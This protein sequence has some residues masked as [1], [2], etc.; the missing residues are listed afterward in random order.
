ML[1]PGFIAAL[2][3]FHMAQEARRVARVESTLAKEL[4]K[5]AEEQATA[6]WQKRIKLKKED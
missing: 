4:A 1:S 3:F 2:D 5:V 6:V